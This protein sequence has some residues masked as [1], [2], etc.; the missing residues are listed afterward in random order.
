METTDTNII[1]VGNKRPVMA[2][3]LACVTQFQKGNTEVRVL[4]RGKAIVRAIDTAEVV[5][6][7]FVTDATVASIEIGT[8]HYPN[9]DEQGKEDGTTTALS[10]IEIVLRKVQ[11]AN[12]N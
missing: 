1:Y 3:V 8:A 11:Q 10:T 9:K 6:R 4:A 7:K 2:Y 5:R 12:G